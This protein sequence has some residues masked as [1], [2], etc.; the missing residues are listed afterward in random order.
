[1]LEIWEL[2]LR[3]ICYSK[4]HPVVCYRKADSSILTYNSES[5]ADTYRLVITYDDSFY[6]NGSTSDWSSAK[7]LGNRLYAV[8]ATTAESNVIISLII[9]T[10]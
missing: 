1:M 9:V 10:I 3:C 5:A 6:G 4:F 2:F 7:A 8:Q